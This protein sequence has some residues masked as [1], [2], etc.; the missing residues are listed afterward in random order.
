MFELK[1]DYN[2]IRVF[3]DKETLEDS[4]LEQLQT[5]ANQKF[6][7]GE[8]IAIM[9]DCH[10]GAGCVIGTTMTLRNRRV[11]PNLVGVDINCGV[12]V[13]ELPSHLRKENVDFARLDAFINAKVP[14][15]HNVNRECYPGVDKM[16]GELT[17]ARSIPIRDRQIRNAIPSLG[18]GN[19]FIEMD[20]D[21]EGGLYF[22]IHTG[23]RN[24]GLQ[25]AM[26]HQDLADK[27][28]NHDYSAY[29]E[30]AN[31]IISEYKSQGRR[32]EIQGVL[33][34]L[35]KQFKESRNKVPRDLAYLEG[36][37]FDDYI[38]D[39]KIC[40]RFARTN[41]LE[42]ASRLYGLL[43]KSVDAEITKDFDSLETWE[44][45]HNYIDIEN[46]ILRK[47]AVSAR[48]GEKILIPINMRDGSLICTGR[49]NAEY[50]YSAPHGAGR[51]MSRNKSKESISLDDF[52]NSMD[53]IWSSC[54]DDKRLD[55]SPMA[56]KS[57]DM[58]LP[59]IRS[60][61][62][63]VRRLKPIYNFKGI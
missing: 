15:G 56:Y 59:H 16:L 40:A 42:L 53:G 18:G 10:A 43:R 30:Q 22:A 37:P 60:T 11:C 5:L 36:E 55:E 58:I 14:I 9:P 34:K 20:E 46:M 54:V 45:V 4:C 26:H 35:K 39:M 6:T 17:C 8:D 31:A 1:G 44:T 57:I 2:V 12:M 19:H 13:V 33:G 3:Q 47:G 7:E 28:C 49:G 52:K 27:Y 29:L 48:Q 62:D 38:H 63:V 50:N 25:V 21:E 61:V 41:R 32:S 51:I 24:L 23:S